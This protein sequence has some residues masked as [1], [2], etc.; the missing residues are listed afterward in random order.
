VTKQADYSEVPWE[1][2]DA[3]WE[4][5]EVPT[6]KKVISQIFPVIRIFPALAKCRGRG[7]Y[8]H[9]PV[10]EWVHIYD[11]RGRLLPLVDDEETAAIR[12]KQRAHAGMCGVR[13]PEN[14]DEA[15]DIPE[16]EEEKPAA[17]EAVPIVGDRQ[18][19]AK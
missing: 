19:A 9:R 3:E 6:K 5:L 4:N 10:W 18:L 17:G 13:M 2:I 12:D 14:L 8:D 16:K 1:T 11:Y 15:V 7:L